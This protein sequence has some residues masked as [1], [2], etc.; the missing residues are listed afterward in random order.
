MNEKVSES[1]C[2]VIAQSKKANKMDLKFQWILSIRGLNSI[3]TDP[4]VGQSIITT[5]TSVS[6]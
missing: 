3:E 4:I 2:I 1:Y 6:W 5:I